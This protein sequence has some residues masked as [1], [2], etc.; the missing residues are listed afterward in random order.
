MR[1]YLFIIF[2]VLSQ[3]TYSQET[4]FQKPDYKK[5]EKAIKSKK[6]DFYYPKLMDRYLNGDSTLTVEEKRH[7]YF[8]Y[9]FQPEY[10]PYGRSAYN[11]SVKAIIQKQVLDPVDYDL[12]LKYTDSLLAHNP[13]DLRA[14]NNR[15]FVYN[16]KEDEKGLMNNV[17]KMNIIFDAILSTGDGT[18]QETAF[19]VIYPTHEYEVLRMIGFSFAGQQSLI[20]N[21]DYLTVKWN[22]YGL[23]G[24]YFDVSPCLKHLSTSIK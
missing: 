14:L 1:R 23:S 15:M 2:L 7:L 21:C 18:S 9:S 24:F 13:L 11:D 22:N 5:I 19:Y 12:L 6:S 10:A 4:N 8:G 17:I 3:L 16:Y 20:G